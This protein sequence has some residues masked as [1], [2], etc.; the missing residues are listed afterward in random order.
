M[1]L[2]RVSPAM[3][4]Y[5]RRR[6]GSG[7]A[8]LDTD[9]RLITDRAERD[10]ILAL[11]IPPAWTDVWICPMPNG[12]LQAV[13]TDAAGRRQYLYHPVWREKRDARKHDRTVHLGAALP[14]ARRTC[15]RELRRGGLTC[16]RVLAASF[17]MLDIASFRV[18]SE[19]YAMDNGTFGLATLQRDHVS[20]DGTRI[21][22]RYTAK[23]SLDRVQSIRDHALARVVGE[24]LARDDPSPD[25]LAWWTGRRWHDVKSADINHAVRELARGDYTAKDFRT[26]NATVLMAQLLAVAPPVT[27]LRE[28]RAA[29]RDAYAGVSQYLGNTPAMAKNSYVDPRIVDLYNDG[30]VIASSVLPRRERR[31]PVHGRV[32]RAVLRLLTSNS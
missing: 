18:G 29:I 11:A 12:H 7:F 14:H 2:R 25:L 8:Y 4:G 19:S 15:A 28:R 9:G 21:T 17:R 1:R 6:A 16:E 22:F 23:G 30:I 26:W 13:G 31:L 27:T 3:P 20:V 5:R 24:L 32:E 10:R